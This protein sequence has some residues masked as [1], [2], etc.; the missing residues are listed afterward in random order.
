MNMM[1]IS[2][3]ERT[4]EIGIR[5]AMGATKGSIQLQFLLEGIMITSIGGII[6][7]VTGVLLAMLISNFLPFKIY[8]DWTAVALTVGVS[9]F[10]GIVFSV[11]PAKSAANKDVIEILR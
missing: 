7:Y 4:K 1:Y 6:G 5:R 11:F 9:V 10:I 2:V 8:T 3:S